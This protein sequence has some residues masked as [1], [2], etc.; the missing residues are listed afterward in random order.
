MAIC[1]N[2]ISNSLKN[3]ISNVRDNKNYN[4]YYMY[5]NIKVPGVLIECGFISNPYDNY[6]LRQDSYRKK[7][8]NL[9]V[10]G[11]I[12]YYYN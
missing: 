9:I 1:F 3:N 8:I 10:N 11:I 12:N 6:N 7:L 5:K 2:G 4:D